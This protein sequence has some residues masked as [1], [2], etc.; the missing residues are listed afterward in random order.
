MR[1][2]FVPKAASRVPEKIRGPLDLSSSI[3]AYESGE[4]DSEEVILLFQHLV[5]TGLAWSLQGAYG[6]MAAGLI[7][8]G[9]VNTEGNRRKPR[10]DIGQ[11]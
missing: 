5:D 4:L 11:N 10:H 1:P 3:I 7:R 2:A 9:L 6:R 8:E